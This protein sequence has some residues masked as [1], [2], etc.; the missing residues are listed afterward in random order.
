[1]VASQ[2]RI[3]KAWQGCRKKKKGKSDGPRIEVRF[4]LPQVGL[5]GKRSREGGKEKGTFQVK[6]TS[7]EE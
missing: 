7:L 3:E 1:V 6:E 2:G 4:I 5:A